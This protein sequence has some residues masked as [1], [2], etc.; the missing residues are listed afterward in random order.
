VKLSYVPI[1]EPKAEKNT[2]YLLFTLH[3]ENPFLLKVLHNEFYRQ[4]DSVGPEGLVEGLEEYH[5][6]LRATAR[7]TISFLL[8]CFVL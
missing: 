3:E 6:F 2:P 1:F 8:P 4:S 5:T 7:D